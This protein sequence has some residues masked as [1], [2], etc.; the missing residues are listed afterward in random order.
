MINTT[1]LSAFA[2]TLAEQFGEA[3]VLAQFPK[4]ITALESDIA[5]ENPLKV[6]KDAELK[7]V[8]SVVTEIYVACGGV[9][10]LPAETKAV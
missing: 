7:I 8:L 3:F 2:I 10:P 4:Y 9:F 6:L 1:G 5:N